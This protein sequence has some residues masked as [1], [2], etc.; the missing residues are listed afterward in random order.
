[1]PRDGRLVASSN[2]GNGVEWN[3]DEVA[4]ALVT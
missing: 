2:P 4:K 1:M 3:E